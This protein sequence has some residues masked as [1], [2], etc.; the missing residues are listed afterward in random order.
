MDITY[1]LCRY[2]ETTD[3]ES[4][5]ELTIEGEYEGEIPDEPWGYYGAT[6]GMAEDA[7]ITNITVAH[8]FYGPF[9]PWKWAPRV[10]YTPWEGTLTPAEET[11]VKMALIEHARAEAE[12]AAEDAAVSAYEAR[13]DY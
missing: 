8:A 10:C 3:E 12:A 5:V 6:P 7:Y 1:T 9:C 13:M 11:A 2:D 4:E